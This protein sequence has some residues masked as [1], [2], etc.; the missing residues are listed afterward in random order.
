MI[1]LILMCLVVCAHFLLLSICTGIIKYNCCIVVALA[2]KNGAFFLLRLIV[3]MCVLCNTKLF[4]NAMQFNQTSYS[5]QT[6]L[7]SFCALPCLWHCFAFLMWSM[8][9]ITIS[10]ITITTHNK[11]KWLIASS[12]AHGKAKQ[13]CTKQQPTFSQSASQSSQSV[14]QSVRQS[15]IQ[16]VMS[17]PIHQAPIEI[18]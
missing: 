16:S 12:K 8:M 13:P 1:I 2:K 3:C 15:F 17:K 11:L 14:S 9:D 6:Q 4:F 10:I 18:T 5:T 7:D